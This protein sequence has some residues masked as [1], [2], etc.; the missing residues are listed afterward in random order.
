M[1]HHEVSRRR[2]V[3]GMIWIAAAALVS[4]DGWAQ[5]AEKPSTAPNDGTEY[6]AKA[7]G[8]QAFGAKAFGPSKKTILRWL[9]AGGLFLNSRGTA[10]MLDP[11]LVN[12]PM[13][14]MIEL[15]IVPAHVPHLDAVLITHS[16]WDHYSVATCRALAS[17][18][19]TF[20][21][22]HYVASLM[23]QE[24]LAAAGHDIGET[25]SVGS[26]R[27][28]LTPADHAWQNVHPKPGQRHFDDSD[29]CGFRIETQDGS[30]WAPGDSRL[31]EAHLHQPVPDALFM[32]FSED[33]WHFS[34]A[35]AAK[36]ANAYPQ[37]VILPSHWG[38]I[39]APHFPPFNGDPAQFRALLTNPQRLK[40]LAPGQPYTLVRI[41]PV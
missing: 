32:D 20:H 8:T 10:L 7:P 39:D 40:T 34:L 4:H 17:A 38:T 27:I 5:Q 16:D 22:T 29:A 12:S 31:M 37:T 25:F 41:L 13:P 24:G 21:S 11:L 33:K 30:V 36:L 28:T 14:F 1:S 23:K 9:G 35:G 6:Q 3:G 26:V 19:R 18:C 2:F 15:P